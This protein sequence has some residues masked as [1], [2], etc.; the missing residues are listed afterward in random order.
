MTSREIE[1]DFALDFLRQTQLSAFLRSMSITHTAVRVPSMFEQICLT[2]KPLR[3][4]LSYL[5]ALLIGLEAPQ[6]IV[7]LQTWERDLGIAFSQVQKDR[8]FLFAHK[9]SLVSRYQEGGYKILT[10]WYRT[11]AVLYR[12]FL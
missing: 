11:P 1:R 9:A 4:L 6:E 8:I 7:F 10:R 5:Y 12:I 2:G 3:H